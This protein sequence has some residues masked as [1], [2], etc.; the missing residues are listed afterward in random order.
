VKQLITVLGDQCLIGGHYML[1]IGNGA[2]DQFFGNR[3]AADQ[4][5]QNVDLWIFGNGEDVIGKGYIGKTEVGIRASRSDLGNAN[6]APN[7]RFDFGL[8]AKN[9][10]YSTAANGTQATYPD[11]DWFQSDTSML[12]SPGLTQGQKIRNHTD[13]TEGCQLEQKR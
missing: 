1:A 10:F 12:T 4:L 2:L 3:R 13:A 7:P 9:H 8:I 5:N 6:C 11:I